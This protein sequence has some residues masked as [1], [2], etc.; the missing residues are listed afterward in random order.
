MMGDQRFHVYLSLARVSGVLLTANMRL[1]K[2]LNAGD[3]V[4]ISF[5]EDKVQVF[6]KQ[7]TTRIA[8]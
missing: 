7:S 6:K 3:E 5:V 2:P 4:W 8:F 1:L